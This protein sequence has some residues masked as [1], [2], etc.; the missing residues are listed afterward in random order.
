MKD[1][2]AIFDFDDDFDNL[3]EISEKYAAQQD[4]E[5][6]ENRPDETP[7]KIEKNALRE[8]LKRE[9]IRELSCDRKKVV[10]QYKYRYR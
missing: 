6:R 2:D 8:N 1:R 7:K 9:A 5:N 3:S 10:L 4:K